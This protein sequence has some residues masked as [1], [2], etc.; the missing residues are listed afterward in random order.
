MA[1]T[2]DSFMAHD[3]FVAQNIQPGGVHCIKCYKAGHIFFQSAKE[4]RQ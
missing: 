1:F 3:Q 4:I 2:M